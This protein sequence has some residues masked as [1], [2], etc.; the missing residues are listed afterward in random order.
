MKGYIANPA[1]VGALSFL[2]K[3]PQPILQN[4]TRGFCFFVKKAVKRNSD[5][6]I[7]SKYEFLTELHY[8]DSEYSQLT[9]SL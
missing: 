4:P 8:T 6:I 5:Y 9:S 3:T 7:I 1:G 2:Q